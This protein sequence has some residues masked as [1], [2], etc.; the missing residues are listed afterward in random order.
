MAEDFETMILV[1]SNNDVT[2]FLDDNPHRAVQVVKSSNKT[3]KVPIECK[4]L[5]S[6]VRLVGGVDISENVEGHS[7]KLGSFVVLAV[8]G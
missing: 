5:Y 7:T 8:Y 1:F 6:M 3:E 4:L 2:I